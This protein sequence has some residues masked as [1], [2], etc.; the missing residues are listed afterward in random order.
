MRSRL[1]RFLGLGAVLTALLVGPSFS[2]ASPGQICT[3]NSQCPAGTLCCYP[4]GHPGC[5]NMCL[6]PLHGHCP[7][8][9]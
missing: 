8:F 1:L 2:Q 5:E 7:F 6:Q 4:C 9:P 3:S